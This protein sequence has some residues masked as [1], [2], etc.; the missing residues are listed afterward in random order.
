VFFSSSLILD[1]LAGQLFVL[2]G[3]VIRNQL[4]FTV[5]RIADVKWL[6]QGYAKYTKMN[7]Q[8]LKFKL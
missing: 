3:L 2:M 1:R 7:Q 8:G 6:K 5:T 4:A